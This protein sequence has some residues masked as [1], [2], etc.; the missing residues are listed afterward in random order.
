MEGIRL[1]Q[2][3]SWY[4]PNVEGSRFRLS[5]YLPACSNDLISFIRQFEADGKR[6]SVFHAPGEHL[7]A[8]EFYDQADRGRVEQQSISVILGIRVKATEAR[9]AAASSIAG[10]VR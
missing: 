3:A 5:R 1:W 4:P 9:Q 10:R 2:P 8:R 7:V 6:N